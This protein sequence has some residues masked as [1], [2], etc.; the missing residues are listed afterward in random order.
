[1][2]AVGISYVFECISVAF[3]LIPSFWCSSR[4]VIP[5]FVLIL[6]CCAP[7]PVLSFPTGLYPVGFECRI[8]YAGTGLPP[9]KARTRVTSKA[10]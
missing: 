8:H 6:R 7:H 1:V 2:Y 10:D 3:A 5:E 4:S 9:T